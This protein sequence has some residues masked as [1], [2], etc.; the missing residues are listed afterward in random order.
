MKG[1]GCG[2]VLCPF[3][4]IA[5]QSSDEQY[6]DLWDLLLSAQH[7]AV[8]RLCRPKGRGFFLLEAEFNGLKAE[9]LISSPGLVLAPESTLHTL[10]VLGAAYRGDFPQAIMGGLVCSPQEVW[11][12]AG[13]EM[14]LEVT[15]YFCFP[16]A[17]MWQNQGSQ[18]LG[19]DPGAAFWGA[20]LVASDGRSHALLPVGTGLERRT[21]SHEETYQ[22]LVSAGGPESRKAQGKN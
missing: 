20:G 7:P 2:E 4:Q 1:R 18:R 3:Y 9:K 11:G 8:T 22:T 15:L 16:E 10:K 17:E 12:Q 21:S 5:V 19:Q 14:C 13:E 6:G